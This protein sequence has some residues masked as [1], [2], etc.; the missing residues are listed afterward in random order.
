MCLSLCYYRYVTDREI[1]EVMEHEKAIL[2]T[3][4]KKRVLLLIEMAKLY[5]KWII[6][7]VGSVLGRK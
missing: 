5:D 7:V 3:K 2:D 1:F 6:Q 4:Y